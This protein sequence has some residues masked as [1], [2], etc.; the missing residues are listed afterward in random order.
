MIQQIKHETGH[1]QFRVLRESDNGRKS[2]HLSEGTVTIARR[3]WRYG[4][5]VAAG[6]RPLRATTQKA[7]FKLLETK[8]KRRNSG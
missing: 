3:K 4:P 1:V 2:L 6:S 5:F 8:G 7:K